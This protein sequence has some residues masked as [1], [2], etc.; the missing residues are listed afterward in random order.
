MPLEGTPLELKPNWEGIVM[1][2]IMLAFAASVIVLALALLANLSEQ[3][4]P[5][6]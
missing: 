3:Y 2:Q 5:G 6:W 4:A 1:K